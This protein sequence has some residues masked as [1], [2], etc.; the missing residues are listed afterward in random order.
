M[1]SGNKFILLLI[2]LNV[3]IDIIAQIQFPSAHNPIII[4][5]NIGLPTTPALNVLKEVEQQRKQNQNQQNERLIKKSQ[6]EENQHKER[7]REIYTEL[8]E[9]EPNIDYNLPD[10]SN[11]KGTEYYR[12]VYDKMTN[13]NIEDY[14]VKDVN[15]EIE[16][17]YFEEK[18]NKEEFDKTIK[19]IGE[20]L[21]AKMKESNYDLRSNTAK[22]FIL[23]EF[24]TQT[25]EVNG[26]KEKH[27][28]IKYD[29]DDYM[30]NNAWPKMF[31]TKLLK[32]GSGQ[33]HSMPLLYLILAEEIRAE[34]YLALSPNHSYIKFQD[35][36]GK[37]YNLE[38]T[39]GMFTVPSFI[40]NSGFI[41][42][43][44]IQNH[45]YMENL[46]KKQLLSNFYN[47]LAEGYIHKYGYDQFVEKVINKALELFPNNINTNV[48][49]FN[50]YIVRFENAAK[51]LGI[52]PEN[53]QELQKIR[54]YPDVAKWLADI[55]N[56]NQKNID[57]G[58]QSMPDEEYEKWL[59][60]LQETKNK[61]ESET[62][63]KQF[64][65]IILKKAKD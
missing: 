62:L 9:T 36:K 46:S 60:S 43:E 51:N 1:W 47:D 61:Q 4:N 20:F 50:Y 27:F 37:W 28:P 33:C 55:D 58:Y 39:N 52:N 31:V 14:S 3:S 38:L 34:A 56:Q 65:G 59:N 11:L 6:Q 35:E 30:G 7:L 42:A 8:N 15:F 53:N 17:A 32:T 18:L 45:I 10:L 41:K 48:L 5:Q 63:K 40:L 13:L 16:N 23:F 26:F 44:A 25:L 2:F 29:F 54:Y 22:N 12:A 49:L 64:K 24:F 57:L 19:Q 21:R